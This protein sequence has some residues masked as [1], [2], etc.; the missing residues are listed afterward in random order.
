[1]CA[2]AAIL[3]LSLIMLSLGPTFLSRAP[4]VALDNN[5]YTEELEYSCTA[6]VFENIFK[7]FFCAFLKICNFVMGFLQPLTVLRMIYVYPRIESLPNQSLK[8]F[9]YNL[10]EPDCP[11]VLFVFDYSF[12]SPFC[13]DCRLNC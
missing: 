12:Y 8:C 10:M 7:L 3:K 5:V 6:L 11:V 2:N 9:I 13:N 4:T 1:M